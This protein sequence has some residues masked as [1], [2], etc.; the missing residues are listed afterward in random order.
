MEILSSTEWGL[1]TAC[2]DYHPNTFVEIN[3]L[4]IDKKIEALSKYTGVMREYPHPRSKEALKGLAAYRGCQAGM[5]YAE[6]FESAF[7]R[8]I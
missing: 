7:R 6:S 4:G 1:N 3:E 2:R 8:E 5:N